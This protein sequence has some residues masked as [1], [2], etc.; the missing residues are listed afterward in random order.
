VFRAYVRKR[1]LPGVEALGGFL[2]RSG[3]GGSHFV[4]GECL[5][6]AG[7]GGRRK[8]VYIRRGYTLYIL[9]SIDQH[10]V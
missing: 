8:E 7:R 10:T 4:H 6:M 5:A 3:G 9:D 1:A 2:V